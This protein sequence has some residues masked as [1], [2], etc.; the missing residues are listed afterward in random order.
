MLL[1]GL[2]LFLVGI[3]LYR[4][5]SVIDRHSQ[6]QFRSLLASLEILAAAAV[7]NALVLGSFVRDRGLKKQR[8]RFD[9]IAGSSSL[10]R[11]AGPRTT[12]TVR[13]WG[14]DA[15]LVEDVGIRLQ[16]G[17]SAD[18]MP[19]PRPAPMA[20]PRASQANHL[21]PSVDNED[22]AFQE[23]SSAEADEMEAKDRHRGM[24]NIPQ[25]KKKAPSRRLSFFDVG[26]LL[27]DSTVV[28]P[29]CHPTSTRQSQGSSSKRFLSRTRTET[30][31]HTVQ[32]NDD[33]DRQGQNAILNDIGG[34]LASEPV[35]PDRR[36][37]S[38]IDGSGRPPPP[39]STQGESSMMRPQDVEKTAPSLND[40]GRLLA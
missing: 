25:P 1:F 40:V 5:V 6:Q 28:S 32:D 36:A 19:G 16:E 21:T 24:E 11:P 4:V 7:S 2:S 14:S 26:G 35:A 34:L 23:R 20:I 13:H 9:S 17:L 22:W 39:P 38:S 18:E 31:K 8:Y 12:M 37:Q 33:D 30:E 15:D 3:T 27:D 29:A 10:D